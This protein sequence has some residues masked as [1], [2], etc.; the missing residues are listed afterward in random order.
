MLFRSSAAW[1]LQGWDMVDGLPAQR[2]AK[3]LGKYGPIWVHRPSLV[4]TGTDKLNCDS[5]VARATDYDPLYEA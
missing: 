3:L 2:L 4:Q 5:Q 1:A